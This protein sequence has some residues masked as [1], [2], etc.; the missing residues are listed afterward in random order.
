MLDDRH[1]DYS[2]LI[3]DKYGKEYFADVIS[4]N[5]ESAKVTGIL[6]LGYTESEATAEILSKQARNRF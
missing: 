5:D 3:T 2:L 6:K 1:Y 4:Y